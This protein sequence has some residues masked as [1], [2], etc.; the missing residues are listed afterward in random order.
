MYLINEVSRQV[1][2]SQKRIREYEKEGFISPQREANTNNRLYS[3]FEISQIKRINYLIHERGFT[4]AC[5]RNL[6][7]LAPCWNIFDCAERA[8][9]AAY[10]EP[11]SPCWRVRQRQ[12][13]LCPGPCQR[14][15]V[16]LNRGHA[17]RRVLEPAG[18]PPQT[19]GE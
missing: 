8:T 9:C 19:Q 11:H 15:A 16:Y 13:T 1:E 17:A 7:V 12:E 2:L 5:L 4:L 3:D 14:C 6:I 10:A 18:N